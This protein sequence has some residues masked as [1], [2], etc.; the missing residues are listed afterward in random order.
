MI[1]LTKVFSAHRFI[2]GPFGVLLLG[3]PS[4]VHVR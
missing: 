1:T 4:G 3:F 2:A